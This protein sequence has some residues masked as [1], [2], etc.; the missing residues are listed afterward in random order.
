MLATCLLDVCSFIYT[1]LKFEL[2]RDIY[3]DERFQIFVIAKQR[4]DSVGFI[5]VIFCGQTLSDSV[6]PLAQKK[7]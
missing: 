5:L 1:Y 3:V 6:R 7:P 4:R 2:V